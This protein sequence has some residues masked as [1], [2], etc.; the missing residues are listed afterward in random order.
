MFLL[1]SPQF[2][3]FGKFP[4]RLEGPKAH[5]GNL[6]NIILRL[7]LC[8]EDAA[9]TLHYWKY[10][11]KPFKKMISCSNKTSVSCLDI[12]IFIALVVAQKSR[13]PPVPA[14]ATNMKS[15]VGSKGDTLYL[16]V[17]PVPPPLGRGFID[18]LGTE[19]VKNVI[20]QV[21]L[22]KEATMHEN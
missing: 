13:Q 15:M 11:A 22:H 9:T 6:L 14:M 18:F 4:I 20:I 8:D 5:T 10:C 16:M 12:I 7:R 19:C 17:R 3:L 1:E 2:L 21:H